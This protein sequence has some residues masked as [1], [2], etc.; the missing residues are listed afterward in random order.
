MDLPVTEVQAE[1]WRVWFDQEQLRTMQEVGEVTGH[2]AVSNLIDTA[3]R[4]LKA[5]TPEKPP[6]GEEQKL[7]DLAFSVTGAKSVDDAISVRKVQVWSQVLSR[8]HA[9]YHKRTSPR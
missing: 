8:R 3:A 5:R 2:S 1:V 7:I 4:K 6:T 9:Y